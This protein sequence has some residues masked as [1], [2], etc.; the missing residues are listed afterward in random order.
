MA[1]GE[2]TVEGIFRVEMVV[3]PVPVKPTFGRPE[4]INKI[5]ASFLDGA[6]DGRFE[7]CQS[8]QGRGGGEQIRDG[9]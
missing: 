3:V 9:R 8:V 7:A 4:R 6:G 1:E 5:E 2:K